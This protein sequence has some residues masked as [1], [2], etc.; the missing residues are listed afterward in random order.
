MTTEFDSNVFRGAR[1]LITGGMGFI[2]SNLAIALVE[3]GARVT[4]VDE[5]ISGYGGNL[6]NIEPIKDRVSINYGDI[7]D[8]NV[9]N[10]LVREQDFVF[11]LAGQVDHI[12]SLQDPFPD[13]DINVK[14]TAVV[15]EACRHHNPAAKV[16]YTGTRGQ[17][18]KPAKLPV[19]EQ[20]PLQP[21][22]IYEITNVA[23]ER[24]VEAYHLVFGVRSCLL[25]ITN[26]Y[27]P[28]AQMRHSRYG[29]VNWFVR[30]ALDDKT[31][32][33]F[34]D[35]RI[36]RDFLYIDD[37]V[38]AIL[39]CAASDCAWG[40]VFNVG[41]DKPSNFVELAETVVR[42]AGSGRWELTPFSPERRAQE[43]G[44]FYSDI[45][46]IRGMLGW[47]PKIGLEE[48]LQR[49]VDYYRK[50]KSHYW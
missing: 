46:K 17:Y 21:L 38:E 44:N 16:I 1:A 28:R 30:L 23:A 10:Y 4:I 22:G 37:C 24:I 50:Y 13:I 39:R 9:M 49:T 42:I 32:P 35:G 15:M 11:H 33:V 18:G 26:T 27:G 48:G 29:V 12:M 34:G 3:R 25:R 43:P 14:G 7:R 8:A 2:G 5:M 31:I 41:V 19:N 45:S 40:E 36:Q 47:Q 6:F 20:A